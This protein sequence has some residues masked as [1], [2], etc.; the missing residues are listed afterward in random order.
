MKQTYT[1]QTAITTVTT[2]RTAATNHA[3]KKT[4]VTKA[5]PRAAAMP[6]TLE[7]S[8]QKISFAKKTVE[9]TTLTVFYLFESF[10]SS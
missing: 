6:A 3:V 1:K 5:I 9:N 2:Q 8:G 4:A 10:Q 7:Q